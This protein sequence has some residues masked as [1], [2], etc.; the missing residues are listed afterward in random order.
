MKFEILTQTSLSFFQ[1]LIPHISKKLVMCQ[2][3]WLF[4]NKN[5]I[6]ESTHE[7]ESHYISVLGKCQNHIVYQCWV[8]V[9]KKN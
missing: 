7:L 5:K 2:L 4:Q 9:P 8:G 3:I 1:N 6:W